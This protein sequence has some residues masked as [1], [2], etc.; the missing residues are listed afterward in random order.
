MKSKI[1]VI[2]AGYVGLVSAACLAALGHKVVCIDR[3]ATKIKKIQSGEIPIY[4]PGLDQWVIEGMQSSHLEFSSDAIGVKAADFVILAVGTPSDAQTGH[5][6]LSFVMAAA[7]EIAPHLNHGCVVITKSTVPVGV[8]RKIENKIRSINPNL[9][10]SVASNPEFLREGTA[11][12]DFMKPDRIVVGA[13]DAATV[14]KVSSLY[15][16][17]IDQGAVL[18]AASLES[19]EMIKYASNAF[20][21]AKIAFINEIAS[22]SENCGADIGEVAKGLGL[23]HRIGGKF[24][25]AGPGFGGSCFPKDILALAATA[26]EFNAHSHMVDAVIAANAARKR[27]M[28]QKIIRACGGDVAGKTIAILGLAFKAGTDDMRDAPS[29]DILG[30]LHHAGAILRCYDPKSMA[31]AKSIMPYIDCAAD[32]YKAANGADAVVIITEWPEF[33]ELDWADIVRHLRQPVVVDLRNILHSNVMRALGVK[34]VS[35]GRADVEQSINLK[36]ITA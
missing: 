14:D 20:L 13:D 5:V 32:S 25:N 30:I 7:T 36:R 31:G 28:A 29:I 17:Q 6:D 21:A 26:R 2:G 11:I 27:I 15:Q 22:V 12:D 19:S 3:D 18:V 33:A 35:I 16:N 1:A 10:F 23:D 9:K 34:Y 8:T 4:E 24:L